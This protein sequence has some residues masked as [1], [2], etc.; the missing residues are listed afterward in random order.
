[1]TNSSP[2]FRQLFEAMPGLYVVLEPDPPRFTIV[3]VSDA[4][5][6]ATMT[7]RED[8]VGR[9]L[10]EVFTENPADPEA[11]GVRNWAE[12]LERVLRQRTPDA[13]AVQ[14]YVLRQP[15][16]A[17]GGFAERWWSQVNS[18]VFGRDGTLAYIVH[19]LDDRT[20]FVRRRLARPEPQSGAEALQDLDRAQAIAKIG[21]WRLDLGRD[22]VRWSDETYR[23]FGISPTTPM[24]YDSF[25]ACVHPDDR[26][27][28]D[29][30]WTAA[31]RGESYDI[32]HRITVDGSVKWVREKA[33]LDFDEQGALRG[34]IGT[35]QDITDRKRLEVLL[36]LA[37]ARSSGIVSISADA[38]ISI[39]EHQRI[40]MF[41]E[42][43]E[44]IFGY[45]RAEAIGA[46]LEI[47]IPERLR[48]IHRQHVRGF[49]EGNQAAR[50]MGDRGLAIFGLR[51]NGE[52]FPADAAISRL[53]VEGTRI[54]AVSL[55]DVTAQK[56]AEA[57]Q[58]FLAEAG[59]VLSSTLDYE[60]TLTGIAELAVRSLADLCVVD[61]VEDHGEVRRLKVASRDPSKAWVCDVLA[62]IQ[63][64]PSR[65][66]LV[67]SVLEAKRP[68][69]L[70]RPSPE[71][72]AL[73]AQ[74]E[75][76]LRALR[77]IEPRS[78]I[79]VPL[80][81]Q[82]TLVGAIALVSSSAS[83]VY[84]PAEVRL[85]EELAVRAS[86]AIEHARLYRTAQRAIQARDEVLGIVAHDL[87]NPLNSILMQAAL[88]RL[89]KS[90]E[91]HKAAKA[92]EGIERAA[93]R[94]NRLIQDLLD[95]TSM[96]A[97]R[98]S[99]EHAR[100]PAGQIV[101]DSVEAQRSLASS[102]SLEL[103]LEVERDLPELWADR[104]RLLQVFENLI[105]N[106]VKFSKP[107]GRIA[108]GATQRDREVVFSVADTGAGIAPDDLPHVFERFWQAR[109]R[110]RRGAGLGLPIV[111]GIVEA[112]GGRIWVESTLGAGSTFF[113]T[114]PIAPRAESR[115]Q[116]AVHA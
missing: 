63:L 19:R 109:R 4:Y 39:D 28:V 95:V 98:L 88:V 5:A 99:V 13:L 59:A 47:L 83:R 8:L 62:Q 17:G 113:F 116:P 78:I 58:T 1:M 90:E 74:N 77:A 30:A 24:T 70:Q 29:R 82:G 54:L 89:F 26:A 41:N 35:V 31:L 20:E 108:I 22:E 49:A 93:R 25:L 14:K 69:L 7:K 96:E 84:G 67:T 11:T 72:I 43:A 2:D 81:T 37:E 36:R 79:V 104:E 23:I 101:I 18:P 40:T 50:R 112:H 16:E 114:I 38:I 42:G 60:Q 92:A 21:S 6:Q 12:S 55:R 33:D 106:A 86:H 80:L 85:T 44:K 73:F 100:V 87:R 32:E 102:A 68:L 27:D 64:D 15:H 71:D 10:F 53:D 110:E 66:H 61:V 48:A 91:V 65:P 9:G 107:G 76:H 97:G 52:E 57:D 45:P 103:W 115:E 94:M 75:E 51:K 111:K 105:G 46:P 56:R 3:A 34:G